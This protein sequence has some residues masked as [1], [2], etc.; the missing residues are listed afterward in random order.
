MTGYEETLPGSG[1][2]LSPHGYLDRDGVV[3]YL[4]QF[5]IDNVCN[6]Y[7]T[8]TV[9]VL[10]WAFTA[11]EKALPC[12]PDELLRALDAKSKVS[13]RDFVAHVPTCMA[14]MVI[15]REGSR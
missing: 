14:C 15:A 9:R 6:D 5:L 2:S 8:Q 1:I 7:N 3:H 11:A 12:M 4:T 13:T 10:C